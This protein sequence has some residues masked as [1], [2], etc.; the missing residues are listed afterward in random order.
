MS[1]VGSCETFFAGRWGGP[2]VSAYVKR[3]QGNAAHRG[4]HD[5]GEILANAASTIKG[6][7]RR[8]TDLSRLWIINEV[9]T[10]APR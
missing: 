3:R 9:G 7:G 1:C 2:N 5:V 10:N 4:D 8:R 6:F